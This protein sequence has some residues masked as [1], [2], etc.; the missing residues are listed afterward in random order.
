MKGT[1]ITC[2]EIAISFSVLSQQTCYST[3]CCEYIWE[4]LLKNMSSLAFIHKGWMANTV[5]RPQTVVFY[6]NRSNMQSRHMF[7]CFAFSPLPLLFLCVFFVCLSLIQ[8]ERWQ[9]FWLII[10]AFSLLIPH[11]SFW[12]FFFVYFICAVIS[13]IALVYFCLFF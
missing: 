11:T 2:S 13:T 10:S 4:V 3:F 9:S 1:V 7:S 12:C 5:F 6:Y 8:N